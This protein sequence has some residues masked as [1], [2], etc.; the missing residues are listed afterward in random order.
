MK[1][2]EHIIRLRTSSEELNEMRLRADAAGLS[3]SDYLRKRGLTWHIPANARALSG[4]AADLG[5]IGN[6]LNQIARAAN[7]GDL[8]NLQ[9]DHRKA[10]MILERR[11][12]DLRALLVNSS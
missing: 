9:A 2:R 3:L 10:L 12:R 4:I 6:N 5:R 8:D 7:R 1:K 11:M